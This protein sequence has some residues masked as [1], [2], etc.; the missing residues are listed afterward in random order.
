[1][2]IILPLSV[3]LPRKTKADK[4]FPLN[5]N[6]Y[7]NAHYTVLNA[8]KIAYKG[9]VK[10]RLDAIA[11][12][13]LAGHLKWEPTSTPV[14]F[15]YTIFPGSN[16]AFDLANVCA[17]VQKFTDDALIELGVIKDDNYK[18]V[19]SIDYR[20]GAVDKLNPRA[21]LDIK[22]CPITLL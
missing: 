10:E 7:R 9:V 17:I 15:T 14:R 19:R 6:I 2:K 13:N 20:F 3:T 4:V 18:I 11:I 8:A 16:R 21:E 1:M 5:L 12:G 22:P